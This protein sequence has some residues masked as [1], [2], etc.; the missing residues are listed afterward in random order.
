MVHAVVNVHLHTYKLVNDCFL[1]IRPVEKLWGKLPH[2]DLLILS[3]TRQGVG[4][5]ACRIES[6]LNRLWNWINLLISPMENTFPWMKTRLKRYP[7]SCRVNK[8]GRTF[9][10]GTNHWIFVF[11]FPMFISLAMIYSQND[12]ASILE[13]LQIISFT[14]QPW[15][16]DFLNNL[17]NF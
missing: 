13:V 8:Q 3:G 7:P 16:A 6:T 9:L 12:E 2:Y 14:A 15:W 17:E 11:F 4:G 10:K 1:S 5:L